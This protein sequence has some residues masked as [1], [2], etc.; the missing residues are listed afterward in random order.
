MSENSMFLEPSSPHREPEEN[1]RHGRL[2]FRPGDPLS[3]PGERGL[4]EFT[5]LQGEQVGAAYVPRVPD[6]APLRLVLLLHGAGGAPR[7]PLDLLQQAADERHLLLLA[8]KS[9]AA[10]WD[11]ILEGYGPDV[12]VIDNLLEKVAAAYRIDALSIGGFSDG[13]SYAL[14]LGLG[15]GDVFDSVLAFSPGF[16]A[17]LVQHGTPRLFVCHGTDDRVLPIDHCSR[18]LV[19]RLLDEGYDVTYREFEGGHTVPSEIAEEAA[20]WLEDPA[21]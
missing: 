20:M 7:Q 19:P 15:N 3:S 5:G 9:R 18:R 4:V 8:P 14:S 1:S 6:D 2:A 21:T 11:V 16:V 17:S 10:T 13:A 12:R